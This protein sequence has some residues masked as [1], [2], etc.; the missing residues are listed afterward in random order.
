MFF[1]CTKY[2]KSISLP[3]IDMLSFG[4]CNPEEKKQLSSAH[5]DKH[6]TSQLSGISAQIS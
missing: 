3:V 1:L 5:E 4:K 2:A 6:I